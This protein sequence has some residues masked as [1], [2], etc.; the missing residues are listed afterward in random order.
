LKL[1]FFVDFN[2]FKQHSDKKKIETKCL[3]KCLKKCI[4]EDCSTM[5]IKEGNIIL[6]PQVPKYSA[7]GIGKVFSSLACAATPLKG[8]KHTCGSH[9]A[10]ICMYRCGKCHGYHELVM[11]ENCV[12]PHPSVKN[13]CKIEA[14]VKGTCG[15]CNKKVY[16]TQLW[17]TKDN[18]Y[19]HF[20]CFS[21]VRK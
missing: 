18:T 7:G 11:C 6:I 12:K 5:E 4:I 17:Y 16:N 1:N 15:G 21:K 14:V 13:Q 8:K 2:F 19:Y 10:K 3:K 20:K 9:T